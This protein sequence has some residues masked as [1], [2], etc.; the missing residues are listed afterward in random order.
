MKKHSAS[1]NIA[2]THWLTSGFA[3]PF[4]LTLIITLIIKVIFNKDVDSATALIVSVSVIYLPLVY[5]LGVMYSARY[6]NKKYFVEN[7]NEI[8]KLSTIYLIVV[9]GGFRLFQ[10]INGSGLTIELIGFVLAVIVFYLASR[11][12]I[13]NSNEQ[14]NVVIKPS[15]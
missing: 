15:N 14:N 11:K 7:S 12:Y 8:A 10:I 1:W 6:I 3:I 2:A 9:G 13:K 5:W 4:V